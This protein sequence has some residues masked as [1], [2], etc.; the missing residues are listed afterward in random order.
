MS[1]KVTLIYIQDEKII[2]IIDISYS[3]VSRYVYV[4]DQTGPHHCRRRL[5]TLHSSRVSKNVDACATSYGSIDQSNADLVF[6]DLPHFVC[7]LQRSTVDISHRGMREPGSV[8]VWGGG[9][10]LTLRGAR[11]NSF[12][13][14]FQVPDSEF[15]RK[16]IFL[17]FVE[18]K[19]EEKRCRVDDASSSSI[20]A[21]HN[22]AARSKATQYS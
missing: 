20:L 18:T 16:S 2:R 10:T 1:K 12:L 3:Q 8:F 11:R 14:R 7:P 9:Q 21:A 5:A 19:G 17:L 22:L 6:S 13:S 15:P 4:A